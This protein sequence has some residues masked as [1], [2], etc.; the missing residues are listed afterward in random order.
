MKPFAELD[1][2]DY[3]PSSEALA[4]IESPALLVYLDRVRDNIARLLAWVDGDAD[5]V[6]PHLKTT[7]IPRVWAELV[8]AGIRHFKCATTR[9]AGCLLEV[10]DAEGVQGDLLVAYPLVE[11]SVARLAEL[12]RRHDRQ[13]V[14]LLVETSDAVRAL[15]RELSAF[16]DVNPGMNRSGVPIEERARIH[17]IAKALGDRF[18]GIHQ[19]EGHIHDGSLDERIARASPLYDAACALVGEL[20]SDGVAVGEVITS[21]TPSFVPALRHEGLR[22]LERCRHRVSPGTVV[23]FDARSRVDASELDFAPAALVL[24]RIVSQPGPG[25]VT[26][27]AGSKAIAAEAGSPVAVALGHGELDARTPSEEHLPFDVTRDAASPARG[28]TLLL[29]PRHVCPTVNLAEEAILLEG[30]EIIARVPV[31][32]RAH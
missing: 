29:V 2:R 22:Q 19:Y 7:K 30:R 14:A 11:P 21:G 10:L 28:T 3:L 13:R 5:R 27:D 31:A 9:E 32:A 23:Y 16:V 12:A 26:C 1:A 8:K 25:I 4:D 6:R 24:S 18:R 15:P 20:E 17:E